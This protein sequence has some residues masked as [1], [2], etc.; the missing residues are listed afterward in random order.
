MTK[1]TISSLP[2]VDEAIKE[3]FPCSDPPPWTLGLKSGL[4]PVKGKKDLAKWLSAEHVSIRKVTV[5]L[6]K[7]KTQLE[8][9]QTPDRELLKKI[10]HFFLV[11]VDENHYQKEACLFNALDKGKEYPSAYVLQDLLH[12][13]LYAKQLHDEFEKA[14]QAE[15]LDQSKLL[16]LIQ[17][18]QHLHHNHMSKEEEYVYPFIHTTLSAKECDKCATAFDKVDKHIS[19]KEHAALTKFAE[20]IAKE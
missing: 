16:R 14:L 1:N 4:K 7:F 3:S 8:N 15:K 13:H 6:N 18:I 20:E 17:D 9:H 2:S 12:E 11:F 19:A 5:A 10:S